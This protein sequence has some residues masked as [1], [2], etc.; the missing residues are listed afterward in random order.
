MSIIRQQGVA[1]VI[2]VH[3]VAVQGAHAAEEIVR[4]LRQVNAEASPAEAVI[5]LR[6]GGSRDDLAAFDDEQLVRAIA[7]SRVPIATAIGH[8]VDTTLADEAADRRFATPS[9][10]AAHIVP[11]RS[12]LRQQVTWMQRSIASD[13]SAL[14]NASSQAA[15]R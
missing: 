13:Y 5:L 14:L 4:A 7:A 12:A 10:A 8:E 11:Q 15:E 1:V 3:D 6:G 9:H 2:T